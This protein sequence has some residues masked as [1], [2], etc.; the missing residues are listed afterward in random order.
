M[1]IS[2]LITIHRIC[3]NFYTFV[4]RHRLLIERLIRQG[5]WYNKLCNA[6]MFQKFAKRYNAEL[7]KYNVCIRTH[8]SEGICIP[9][10][11]KHDRARKVTTRGGWLIH[12]VFPR[13]VAAATIFFSA[14]NPRRLFEGGVY[15]RAAFIY[16]CG[17]I[18]RSSLSFF[19]S[20]TRFSSTP[21]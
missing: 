3:D 15:S 6:L 12:T 10:E 18:W 9:L 1:Y 11:V 21:K 20:R 4:K 17:N 16:F 8:V 14:T 19:H 2:Q 5:F 13:L 7:S